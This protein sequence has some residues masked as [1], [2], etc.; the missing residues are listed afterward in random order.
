MPRNQSLF[1]IVN[2]AQRLSSQFPDRN[3]RGQF[4]VCF[5]SGT[6]LFECEDDTTWIASYTLIDRNQNQVSFSAE[7]DSPNEAR[8]N[9]SK[10]ILNQDPE[11]AKELD[12]TQED[13]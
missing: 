8:K 5:P 1:D 6:V 3:I 10:M 13:A 11:L 4:L 12:P 7:G 2:S 9:L